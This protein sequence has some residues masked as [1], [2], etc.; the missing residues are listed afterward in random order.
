MNSKMDDSEI[1]MFSSLAD[2][3]FK[4]CDLMFAIKDALSGYSVKI[5][6]PESLDMLLNYEN[7]LLSVKAGNGSEVNFS[8]K[9]CIEVKGTDTNYNLGITFNEGHT[10]TDW[11]TFRIS[12]EGTDNVKL[13]RCEGGY[14]LGSDNLKN[15]S[16]SAHND[17]S[18]AELTLTTEYNQV[19]LYE[20]DEHTIGA[21]VDTDGDG[22]FETVLGQ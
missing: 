7:S 6:E 15:V 16:V 21:A 13:E 11:Y 14:I 8:P 12:G 4:N 2:D 9:G 18:S 10:V 5:D 3:D 1:K 19:Y 17:S 20:I 22:S